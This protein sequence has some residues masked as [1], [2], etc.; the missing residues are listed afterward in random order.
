[1]GDEARSSRLVVICAAMLVAI[2]CLACESSLLEQRPSRVALASEGPEES[3]SSRP[4]GTAG[5]STMGGETTTAPSASATQITG[6][7]LSLLRTSRSHEGPA[8][9][10]AWSQDGRLVASS[11]GGADSKDSTIVVTSNDG[12]KDQILLGH[13]EPV[14]S[15]AWSPDGTLLA[16]GSFDGTIRLWSAGGSLIRVLDAGAPTADLPWRSSQPVFSVAWSPDGELLASG[17]VDF[18]SGAKATGGAGRLPG[19]VRVW[20]PKG[21]LTR[22]LR[23]EQTGGKFLNLGWSPDGELIVAGAVDYGI[24]HTDGASVAMFRPG[25]SPVWGMAWSPDG[26][27]L[28]FGDENGNLSLY[29]TAGTRQESIAYLPPISHLA[30][31]PDGTVIAVAGDGLELRQVGGLEKSGVS[32]GPVGRN[33]GAGPVW[34]PAGW[35]AAGSQPT[36][37][38]KHGVQAGSFTGCPTDTVAL[39][40]SPDGS[41]IAG[42]SRD[43]D[44]CIWSVG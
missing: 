4:I 6:P 10:L 44:V 19:V 43:G 41:Y 13:S 35:L 42:G 17:S 25:A 40:W 33:E 9:V 1:M 15:L 11:S 14:T 28:A 24:W 31:S 8:N 39:S 5:K 32:L 12:A 34:S 22:T 23:T 26:S 2:S 36:L 7:P 20:Q 30:F 38:D 29:D 16:S 18:L 27:T 3:G 21:T 37:W